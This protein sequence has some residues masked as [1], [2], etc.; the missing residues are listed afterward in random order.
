M[1]SKP[2]KK[3]N[4]RVRKIGE[5][6]EMV[7]YQLSEQEL[8]EKKDTIMELLEA[9]EKLEARKKEQM[10]NLGSQAA[11]MELEISQLRADIRAKKVTRQIT[12]AEFLT[13]ANE[14]IRVRTDTDEQIGP[15]RTA[16][17]RELQ[18]ELPLSEQTDPE[19][20][21]DDDA[22]DPGGDEDGLP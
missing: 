14:V 4:D 8:A 2:K 6:E 3:S 17:S 16:T 15:P 10:K 19:K 12:V 13:G 5:R 18:E 1:S 21:D 20:T 11:T 22:F 7:E 9:L